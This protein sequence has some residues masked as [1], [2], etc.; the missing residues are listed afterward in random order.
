MRWQGV[1]SPNGHGRIW[2]R[3]RFVY[4][5]VMAYTLLVGPVPEGLQLDHTC[6]VRDCWNVKHLEPV[7][8]RENLLRGNTAAALNAAKTHCKRG[9]EFTPENTNLKPLRGGRS[10]AR[11]CITCRRQMK[12]ERRERERGRV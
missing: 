11:E 8:C 7:T 6:R 5:H 3:G 4:T 10:I 2:Y 9:H 1:K 12:R